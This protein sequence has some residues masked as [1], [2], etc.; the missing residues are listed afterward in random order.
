MC[1]VLSAQYTEETP[2]KCVSY[3]ELLFASVNL[4]MDTPLKII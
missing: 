3:F 1:I 2:S 4:F